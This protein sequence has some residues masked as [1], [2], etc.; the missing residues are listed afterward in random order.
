MAYEIEF[1]AKVSVTDD[2][3]YI[4]DCCWGA[5]VIRDR[6]LPVLSTN[7]YDS[8]RTG[9]EDWGWYIWMRRAKEL[10]RV[11]IQCDNKEDGLFRIQVY[12]SIRKWLHWKDIDLP[13][14]ERTNKTILVEI[15][16]WGAL[17][18][19]QKFTPDFIT[20]L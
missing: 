20:E 11:H 5:D 6:L 1:T 8:V 15:K 3:A 16:K 19:V 10:T 13:E 14:V 4:N 12:S 7:M 9:Q 17:K 18:R 2:E